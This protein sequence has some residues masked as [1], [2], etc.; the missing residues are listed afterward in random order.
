[1]DTF[2]NLIK[3]NKEFGNVINIRYPIVKCSGLPS[4]KIGE[5]VVFE[6]G[7]S[8]YVT[9]LNRENVEIQLLTK[10]DV[11]PGEKVVSSR[12]YIQFGINHSYLGLV[13]DPIGEVLFGGAKVS[14]PDDQTIVINVD[15][16]PDIS[17]RAQITEPL[18]TGLP[19]IDISIPLGMGQREL[20]VGSRKT[21]KTYVAMSIAMTQARQGHIVIFALIGK[22]KAEIKRVYELLKQNNLL[23]NVIIVASASDDSPTLIELTPYAAMSIAEYFADKGRD[24]LVLIDDM[25]THAQVHRELSLLSGRFP[26]RDSYPGDIFYKHAQLLERA[27]AFKSTVSKK[28]KSTITCLAIAESV[29]KRL[30]DYIISNLIGI[31]DGHLLFDE[32]AF[33]EGRRPAI[34]I[35]LSVTRVGKQTQSKIARSVNRNLYKL[36]NK[37][38]DASR[39]RH[40]GA[41]LNERAARILDRGEKVYL[42]FTQDYSQIIPTNAQIVMLV[43]IINGLLDAV[44]PQ[45]FKEIKMNFIKNYKNP[46][47]QKKI[48]AIVS[49]VELYDDLSKKIDENGIYF[50]KLCTI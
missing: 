29:Q 32:E 23:Q 9:Q 10:A 40:F 34:E 27:G 41:E 22:Q 16:V 12:G 7:A 30:N 33:N 24:V 13:L 20:I 50:F 14:S 25:T 18:N 19:A 39:F 47:D 4:I 49:S 28:G 17:Q 38:K 48:D 37:Y 15:K 35:Y 2:D 36:M 5:F 46:A 8:G 42:F 3:K 26:G 44:K 1:M 6:K 31:T 21:G 11:N 43:M 45:D